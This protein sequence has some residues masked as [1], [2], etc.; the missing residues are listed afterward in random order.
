MPRLLVAF[1][2]LGVAGVVAWFV[3]S[4]SQNPADSPV[5]VDDNADRGS[6]RTEEKVDESDPAQGS[7][8]A[9]VDSDGAPAARTTDLTPE[10]NATETRSDAPLSIA[11]RVTDMFGGALPNVFVGAWSSVEGVDPDLSVRHHGAKTDEKGNYR[12][13]VSPGVYTVAVIPR[14]SIRWF[15]GEADVAFPAP[16]RD[17]VAAGTEHVDLRLDLPTAVMGKV[18]D[19]KTGKPLECSFRTRWPGGGWSS[20]A[21]ADQ[22]PE[23]RFIMAFPGPVTFELSATRGWDGYR[24]SD[25]VRIELKAGEVKRDVIL[26]LYKGGVLRGRITHAQGKPV[27]FASVGLM[28]EKTGLLIASWAGPLPE[29]GRFEVEGVAT[30]MATV[31]VATIDYLL[32]KVTGVA[33]RHDG[34][35]EQDVVVRDGGAIELRVE[36][37]AGKPAGGLR[38]SL[39]ESKSGATIEFGSSYELTKDG[40]SHSVGRLETD[41]KGV[42]TRSALEPGTYQV[43]VAAKGAEPVEVIVAQGRTTKQVVVIPVQ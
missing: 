7:G 36:D 40:Y 17:G 21:T 1:L 25:P 43:I 27:R 23:G 32:A 4:G 20:F 38:V 12:I 3:Y 37:T 18:V 26:R 28:D 35:V 31:H 11:G 16:R 8:P 13:R 41:D 19:G 39:K 29:D 22:D 24:P 15:G 6:L 10:A 30:A 42:V 5:T 14:G 33:V 9:S 2:V 34:V